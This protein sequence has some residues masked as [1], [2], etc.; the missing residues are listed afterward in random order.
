MKG[1]NLS[2]ESAVENGR[3]EFW[4]GSYP[5]IAFLAMIVLSAGSCHALKGSSVASRPRSIDLRPELAARGVV[6]RGQGARGTCSVFTT[7]DAIEFALS[8]YRGRPQSLSVEFLNWAAS[9]FAGANSDGAFFHNALGGFEQFGICSEELLPYGTVYNAGLSPSKQALDQAAFMRQES[10]GVLLVHWI[11]PW[12]PN[13]FGVNET[14]FEQ[15]KTT[16]A[17]GY[18]VAAGSGHSRLLVGFRD[19]SASAGGG[20]FMTKDSAIGGFGEVTYEFVRKDVA[21][22]FWVEARGL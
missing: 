17:R 21:D 13:H 6:P 4:R 10:R 18:P 12:Q 2:Q 3:G 5:R 14:Q 7:C 19:D 20:I 22:V 9:R 16:L 11:V 1:L 8:K 15:I